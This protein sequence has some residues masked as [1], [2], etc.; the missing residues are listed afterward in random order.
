MI[1][2]RITFLIYACLIIPLTM[3]TSGM[4]NEAIAEGV[5]APTSGNVYMPNPE[6][7]WTQQFNDPI[8]D[9]LIRIGLENSPTLEVMKGRILSARGASQ[10]AGA[11]VFPSLAISA[12][13]QNGD[14]FDLGNVPYSQAGVEL[15]YEVDL[16]SKTGLAAEAARD[17]FTASTFDHQSARIILV[18][19][20]AQTYT[21]LRATEANLVLI[22]QNLDIAEKGLSIIRSQAE[23]G[24]ETQITIEET[25]NLKNGFAA[26]IPQT[27]A[28]ITQYQLV[29]S[30]LVG[31]QVDVLSDLL[32]TPAAIPSLSVLPLLSEPLSMVEKR[33]DVAAQKER[34]NATESDVE[35]AQ[36]S[37]LPTISLNAFYG[38][39]RGEVLFG[40]TFEKDNAWTTNLAARFDLLDFGL[41][42]S[43][44][45]I[46]EGGKQSA[47]A[48]YRAS[49]LNALT[50]I[51]S[52]IVNYN[53]SLK[54]VH[55]LK[56]S[57]DNAIAAFDLSFVLYEQGELALL[58]I[59]EV[60]QV[61]I[62]ADEALVNGKN[63][64][65]QSLISVYKA[66]G[67]L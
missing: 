30:N 10:G 38:I 62:A 67:V 17:R 28:I 1:Q 39:S 6:T 52:A 32:N 31:E 58:D 55:Y 7:L 59:L 57:R 18:S 3:T 43:G 37:W 5:D 16:F 36:R 24:E 53:K 60:K 11:R 51:E 22:K 33:P 2:L 20:I 64:S 65:T 26:R 61:A 40:G 44:V 50:E 54:E 63:R 46:A 12:L 21:H 29:L 34:A 14:T 56:A 15:A 8:L 19:E 4:T 27:E 25:L 23:F 66:L 47:I 45:K 48:D 13:N 35:S 49:V 9:E 42:D 41:N